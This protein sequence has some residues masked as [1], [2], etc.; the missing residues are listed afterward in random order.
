MAH[1]AAGM[2]IFLC[3]WFLLSKTQSSQ[4]TKGTGQTFREQDPADEEEVQRP[5][6]RFSVFRAKLFTPKRQQGYF[7]T[8]DDDEST[9]CPPRPSTAQSTMCPKRKNK[10]RGGGFLAGLFRRGK[11]R[12]REEFEDED[13]YGGQDEKPVSRLSTVVVEPVMSKQLHLNFLF[14]GCPSAGQT[15]LLKYELFAEK[16][17]M[18]IDANHCLVAFAMAIFQMYVAFSMM[19]KERSKEVK[20]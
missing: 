20:C 8:T 7:T 17:N 12:S 19:I 9:I 15:S 11:K 3:S 1:D 5:A 6:S 14:V 16:H 10:K 18:E 2:C 4:L 13:C